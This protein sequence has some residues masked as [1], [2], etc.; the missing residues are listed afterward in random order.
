MTS[1]LRSTFLRFFDIERWV[2]RL[3]ARALL[4]PSNKGYSNKELPASPRIAAYRR[5]WP[6]AGRRRS[7]V[8]L[9]STG[10]RP[11]IQAD[12]SATVR[13]ALHSEL[14]KN[15]VRMPVH[16]DREAAA[17]VLRALP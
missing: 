1:R 16:E 17:G 3:H 8:E 9:G 5:R 13:K 6:P 11:L 12:Y 14:H 4:R 10:T 15:L 7:M 2:S